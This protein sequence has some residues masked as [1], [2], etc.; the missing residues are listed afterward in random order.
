MQKTL[1]RT[2]P[3]GREARDYGTGEGKGGGLP[4]GRGG[5]EQQNNWR[6]NKR[7][8]K[9]YREKKKEKGLENR[10]GPENDKLL[11]NKQKRV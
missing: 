3:R 4:M 5:E 6:E 8:G 11:G 2:G 7:A 10:T 1:Q 9:I